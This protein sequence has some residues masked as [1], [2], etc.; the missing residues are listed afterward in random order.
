MERS[1]VTL[2]LFAVTLIVWLMYRIQRDAGGRVDTRY[3]QWAGYVFAARVLLLAL[4]LLTG[5]DARGRIIVLTG[6]FTG[7]LSVHF[8]VLFAYSFPLNKPAPRSLSIPL[9][10]GT[11]LFAVASQH[12]AL[13]RTAGPFLL[14]FYVVP[15]FSMTILF[16][17]RNWRAATAPGGVRPSA[18]VTLV[19]ASVL[20]PWAVSMFLFGLLNARTHAAM[21]PWTFLVQAL[22]MSLIVVGGTGVAILRYHLFEIRVVMAEVVMAV[23]AAAS[24]AGY[25]GLAAAPLYTWLTRVGSSELA[26][27]VVAGVP[28]F[29]FRVLFVSVDRATR[30]MAAV[31]GAR[32]TDRSVVERVLAV[33]ARVVDPDG[34]LSMVTASLAEATGCEVTFLRHGPVAGERP[35]APAELVAVAEEHA[36]DFYSLAQAPELPLGLVARM[37]LLDAQLVIPVRRHATL[38]GFLVVSR[39]VPCTRAEMQVGVALAEHLAVKFE[40]HALYAERGR[41]SRELEESRRLAA[42]GAF[43]AAVAHDIR[44]PLT[45]IQMNVQILRTREGLAEGD[46]EYLEIALVEIE[47]LN[48]SVGEILDFARP[49]TLMSAPVDARDVAEDVARALRPVYAERGLSL[50]VEGAAAGA[51]LV[52]LDER[53]VRQVLTNLLDNAAAAS[54]AR[55]TVV[56][57]VGA[58]GER[59]TFAVE[60]RG[61]GIA[62]ENVER[63]F[64]PF[65]TTRADGTGLGLAIAQKVVRAHGGEIR[66]EPRD[67][68]GTRFVVS[69]P[70]GGA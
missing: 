31:V 67:G 3:F 35:E 27:V 48:R 38:Y 22:G 20:A 21:P 18:P 24:F 56:L 68:G 54:P 55:S 47:R 19:Q 33:T 44:T 61:A 16:L 63:I 46:R 37:E 7:L 70:R 32:G 25:V 13:T 4:A 9:A 51:E 66:V 28:P 50:A 26:A 12:D 1:L 41:L 62:P 59:A 5:I 40:N 58:A 30:R 6:I 69:L 36:R 34:V 39:A 14:L 60:D 10:L 2:A 53:R 65:F 42:L 17:H 52:S 43:A 57:R 11:G 49:L 29:L 23:V 45:S 15:Y 64:E 8:L